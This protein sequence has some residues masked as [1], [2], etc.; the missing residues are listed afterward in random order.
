MLQQ[1]PLLW[2]R[3]RLR[4]QGALLLQRHLQQRLLALLV[5]ALPLLPGLHL[6]QRRHELLTP[7]QPALGA[8]A[9]ALLKLPL[10]P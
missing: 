2:L 5:K 6:E 4:H 3:L 7:G 8:P 9:A 1:L 10:G